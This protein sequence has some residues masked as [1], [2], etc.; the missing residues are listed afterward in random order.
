LGK[1]TVQLN[2]KI[3]TIPKI[4]IDALLLDYKL[5]PNLVIVEL[6]GTIIQKKDHASTL[7]GDKDTIEIIR[8]I[9]GGKIS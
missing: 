1:I 8:Y 9:G 6:N 3:K 7:L 2:G 5:N 4:T